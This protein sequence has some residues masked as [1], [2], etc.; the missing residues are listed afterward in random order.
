MLVPRDAEVRQQRDC[1]AG[2]GTKEAN[3]GEV[4]DHVV[5]QQDGGAV[6][7]TVASQ[8]VAIGADGA[9]AGL[10]GDQDRGVLLVRLEAAGNWE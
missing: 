7:V 8:A 10:I 9:G 1:T 4:A 5:G 6:V 3:D 2:D